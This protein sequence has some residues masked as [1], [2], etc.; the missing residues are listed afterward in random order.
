MRVELVDGPG[1][2]AVLGEWAQ[3]HAAD[4]VATPFVSA[5]WARAW[6]A[7]WPR[8]GRPWVLLVRRGPRLVGV[9]P[10]MLERRGPVRVLGMLGKEP[11]DYWDVVSAPED[12]DAVGAA[13]AGELARRRHEWDVALLSCLVPGSSTGPALAAA[14]LRVHRRAAVRCPAI[15]LPESWEAYLAT[16]PGD[17]RRNVRRHLRRVDEGEVELHEVGDPERLPAVLARWQELRARQWDERGRTLTAAHRADAFR[18]FLLAAVT[19]LAPAGQAPVWTLRVGGEAA[20]VYVGF[21]DRRSFYWYLGGYD[22]AHAGLGLGKIAIATGIRRSIE[23]G[24]ARYDF[25]RGG[26]PYKYWYGASDRHAPSLVVGSAAARSRV[27]LPAAA[28]L[29][30]RRDR[31]RP[32]PAGATPAAGR[33]A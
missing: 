4:P 16:L 1:V 30:A 31:A 6:I 15:D 32:A 5:A 3:L 2:E 25:T 22:P 13:V 17:R 33:S 23:C 29:A 8:A 28:A 19:A 20:G 11:G 14:G 12:R 7:H 18:D 21:A 26:E 10:L 27:L 9:A 24:R